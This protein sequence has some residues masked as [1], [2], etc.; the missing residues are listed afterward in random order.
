LG[1]IGVVPLFGQASNGDPPTQ[2]G[3]AGPLDVQQ[4]SGNSNPSRTTSPTPVSQ[5]IPQV[6][7]NQPLSV[8]PLTGMTSASASGFRPLSGKDR[9]YLYWRQNFASVGAYLGPF[10]TALVPDQVTGSPTQWGGGFLGYGR[11]LGSRTAMGMVQGTFQASVAA[12]MHE[13]VR[14]ISSG[15]KGLKERALHALSYSFLTYNN[16]GRAVVNFA[17]LASFYAASAIST[18]WIPGRSRGAMHT[19]ADGTMQIAFSVPINLL[20]EFWPDLRHKIS[21]HP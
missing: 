9:W 1:L 19:L 5:N 6:N 2:T 21:H 7:Q 20:Q 12:V 3:N 8:N 13:D 11:R 15:Q 18:T 4:Q 14:Y 10:I 17:N 16:Q